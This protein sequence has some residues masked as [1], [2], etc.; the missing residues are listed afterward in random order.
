MKKFGLS[1]RKNHK[2]LMRQSPCILIVQFS[3]SPP[4]SSHC[5]VYPLILECTVNDMFDIILG[6][7]EDRSVEKS[8]A[9][10]IGVEDTRASPLLYDSVSND[11]IVSS[12][13][14]HL[15]NG[16]SFTIH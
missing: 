15:S 16:E 13:T 9:L 4:K 5:M 14:L 6:L 3:L 11:V 2:K 1:I 8:G 7:V 10:V 12:L